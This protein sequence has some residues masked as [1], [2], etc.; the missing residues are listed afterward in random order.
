MSW[1]TVFS[2]LSDEKYIAPTLEHAVH[3]ARTHDAH[4]DVLCLGVGR[5]PSSHYF[6]GA[7]AVV[8]QDVF[9]A[10]YDEADALKSAA[11]AYLTAQDHAL[12]STASGVAQLADL[13]RHVADRAR[14]ADVAVLPAPYGDDRGPELATLTE[15]VMFEARVPALVL[16]Q[17]NQANL[18]PKTVLLAWNDGPEAMRAAREALPLLT[19]ADRVYVVVVDPP[20]HGLHRSDPGGLISQYLVRHGVKVEVDVLSKSLPRVADVLLRRA[21]DVDADLVVMGAYGHSRFREA[22]FG[23]ATRHMLEQSHLPI[24]M[25]H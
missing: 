10:C 1:K 2:A 8:L 21:T 15:A 22:I 13:D 5:D 7:G 3:L 9:N 16:P 12:W 4:L 17:T 11:D 24:L 25:A 19:N 6:S 18:A 14:F 23:G 20:E